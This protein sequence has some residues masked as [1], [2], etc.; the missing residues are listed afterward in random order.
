EGG[1]GH[2]RGTP[3]GAYAADT[4]LIDRWDPLAANP[5]GVWDHWLGSGLD[6]WAAIADS[7]FHNERDDFWPCEFAA[8]GI[9]APDRT[10]DGVLRAL[11]AGSF[12]AE[13]GHIASEVELQVRVDG[14]PRPV[15]SGEAI[16]SKAG[17]QATVSLRMTV[18]AL[19]YLGR[20]N[21]IDTV[22][23]IAI[24]AA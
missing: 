8:T 3:L 17:D 23:L 20:D 7:D 14:L 6:V 22:E 4:T 9:Y 15:V 24:S 10:V 21:H 13:H 18:P 12:F 19:D 16:A 11:H 2:Q 5:D 1:P